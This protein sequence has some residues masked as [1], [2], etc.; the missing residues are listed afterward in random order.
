MSSSV[1][2]REG[3][4]SDKSSNRAIEKV[5]DPVVFAQSVESNT[6]RVSVVQDFDRVAVE[7]G[8]DG[9]REVGSKAES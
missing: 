6:L 9:A 5:P 1:P 8:D 2:L 4:L 3:G 7:D